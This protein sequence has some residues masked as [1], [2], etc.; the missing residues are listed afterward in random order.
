MS[1]SDAEPAPAAADYDAVILAGGAARRLGGADKPGAVV[2][3][4]SLVARVADAVADAERLILVGPARSELPYALVVRE[5]PPGGGPVPALRAG[6]PS[7]R[8]PWTA[9]L[10]AD[11]PFLRPADLAGLL[12]AAQGRSGAV[13]ADTGGRLQWL[14]GVWRTEVLRAALEGYRGSRLRGLLGPLEPVPVR[15]VAGE[16]P[17]WFD[18][19]TPADLDRAARLGGLG[20][21]PGIARERGTE[22][23]GGGA[24]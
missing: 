10:A 2:G 3:G 4:R 17:A 24:R 21:P 23:T 7:A 22:A 5:E 11:L 14:A 16:R 8:A 15:P 13:L 19:D 18:C 20:R 9:L 1:R 6:L 12:A